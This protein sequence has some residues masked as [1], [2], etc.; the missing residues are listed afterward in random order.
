ML[1]VAF[2]DRLYHIAGKFGRENV[3]QIYSFQAF[4]GK[5]LVNDRSTK[6]LLIVTTNLPNFPTTVYM[7][8]SMYICDWI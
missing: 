5:S 3:W 4:G 7:A 6:R 8:C 2:H 1:E